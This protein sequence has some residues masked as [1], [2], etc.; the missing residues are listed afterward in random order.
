M[1]RHVFHGPNNIEVSLVV[2]GGKICGKK[3]IKSKDTKVLLS[4]IIGF[5]LF[6]SFL[7]HRSCFLLFFFFCLFHC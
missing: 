2:F 7:Y 3:K 1:L 4:R 6:M 5:G